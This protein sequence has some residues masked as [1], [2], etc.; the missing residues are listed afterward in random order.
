MKELLKYNPRDVIK[1]KYYNIHKQQIINDIHG[2]IK[3]MRK[4]IAFPG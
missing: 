4:K 2:L 3:K 1:R